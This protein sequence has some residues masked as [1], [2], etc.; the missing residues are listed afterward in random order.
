MLKFNSNFSWFIYSK[1]QLVLSGSD[2]VEQKFPEV[3]QAELKGFRAELSR[4]GA[5]QFSS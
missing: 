4:A 2:E 5:F 1:R 3:S